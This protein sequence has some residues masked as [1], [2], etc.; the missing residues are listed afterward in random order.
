MED[1]PFWRENDGISDFC[2]CEF[3]SWIYATEDLAGG[4]YRVYGLR[5]ERKDPTEHDSED[6]EMRYETRGS[7]TSSVGF[8][9]MVACERSLAA[10]DE[11][12]Y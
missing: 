11:S 7:F 1:F 5:N 9:D 3:H 2:E 12:T 4:G 8:S 6:E 10:D